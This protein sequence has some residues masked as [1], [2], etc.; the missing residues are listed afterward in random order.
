MAPVTVLAVNSASPI[1]S[2]ARLIDRVWAKPGEVT[3]GSRG[4]RFDRIGNLT[5]MVELEAILDQY[6]KS[7]GFDRETLCTK[8]NFVYGLSSIREHLNKCAIVSVMVFR[9]EIWTS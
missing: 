9:Y 7:S 5:P 1:T 3:Y 8:P 6:R 2:V 4:K